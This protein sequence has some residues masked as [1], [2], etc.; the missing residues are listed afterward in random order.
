MFE[1]GA[2]TATIQSAYDIVDAKWREYSSAFVSS[3]M[4]NK[5]NAGFNFETSYQEAMD[6]LRSYGTADSVRGLITFCQNRVV[7]SGKA[8][9]VRIDDDMKQY[10]DGALKYFFNQY[11]VAS[12]RA[13]AKRGGYLSNEVDDDFSRLAKGYENSI[14]TLLLVGIA[15]EDISEA[16]GMAKIVW[17]ASREQFKY[18]LAMNDI[19]YKAELQLKTADAG[20]DDQ[21][22]WSTMNTARPTLTFNTAPGTDYFLSPDEFWRLFTAP[23]LK[24]MM[25]YSVNSYNNK[26]V[27]ISNPIADAFLA[28][29]A[30]ENVSASAGPSENEETPAETT[31]ETPAPTGPTEETPAETSEETPAP[32]GPTENEAAAGEGTADSTEGGEG[33]ATEGAAETTT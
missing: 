27:I 6:A 31:E 23:S 17:K 33:E 32:T 28:A 29:K 4:V 24:A 12:G 13:G 1:A 18:M 2:D 30:D 7:W 20:S 5:G 15:P 21:T 8:A 11:Q 26:A 25:H 3:N 19:I 14:S 10:G 9:E 22:A 16:M